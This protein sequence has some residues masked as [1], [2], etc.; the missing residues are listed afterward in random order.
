M[1]SASP[2]R[3]GSGPGPAGIRGWRGSAALPGL[4][5]APRLSAP[6]STAAPPRPR[7]RHRPGR[8]RAVASPTPR[9]ASG[10]AIVSVHFHSADAY[11]GRMD[12]ASIYRVRTAP[13][14]ASGSSRAPSTN[15]R[16]E[17]IRR[18]RRISAPARCARTRPA[19]RA[20]AGDDDHGGPAR[21]WP[22]RR[23]HSASSRPRP[24]RGGPR[25][26]GSGGPQRPPP[27]RRLHVTVQAFAPTDCGRARAGRRQSEAGA[28][29][30]VLV[31]TLVDP[32][33]HHGGS[34][35]AASLGRV[36]RH[37]PAGG[38]W[39]DTA[40]ASARPPRPFWSILWSGMRSGGYGRVD[41]CE[42]SPTAPLRPSRR[43]MGRRSP[44]TPTPE[45]TSTPRRGHADE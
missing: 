26:G 29:S 24:G 42:S 36:G 1:L 28:T 44:S 32:R 10:S 27:C 20:A 3:S 30:T 12:G 4:H 7:P 5:A 11:A 9:A 45:R 38:A 34:Y 23:R 33:R 39:T 40:A 31:E 6:P 13:R 18:G 41:P 43:R 25:G 22:S 2:R 14:S 35:R 8:R 15:T 19:L 21:G 16:P 37:H 17:T